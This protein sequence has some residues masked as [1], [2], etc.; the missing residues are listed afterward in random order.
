MFYGL[1][2]NLEEVVLQAAYL[3]TGQT[4][5]VSCR[6]LSW[7]GGTLRA[8]RLWLLCAVCSTEKRGAVGLL[9]EIEAPLIWAVAMAD[10]EGAHVSFHF[11]FLGGGDVCEYG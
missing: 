5:D 8:V 11:P 3:K 1:D 2:L 4:V 9:S 7:I 6:A 10:G